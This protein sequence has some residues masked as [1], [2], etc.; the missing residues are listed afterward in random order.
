MLAEPFDLVAYDSARAKVLPWVTEMQNSSP[1]APP[2]H[3]HSSRPTS[4]APTHTHTHT[5]SQSQRGTNG[6]HGSR[7]DDLVSAA[8]YAREHEVGERGVGGEGTKGTDEWVEE[9][10]TRSKSESEGSR[11]GRREHGHGHKHRH[12]HRREKESKK[13]GKTSKNKSKSKTRSTKRSKEPTEESKPTNGGDVDMG[14]R[15]MTE[16]P[17]QS[18]FVAQTDAGPRID[19]MQQMGTQGGQYGGPPPNGFQPQAP[20]GGYVGIPQGYNGFLPQPAFGMGANA[21]NQPGAMPWGQANPNQMRSGEFPTFNP[22]LGNP[23]GL[24]QAFHQGEF[25]QG[26]QPFPYGMPFQSMPPQQPVINPV[27]M[28]SMN[29]NPDSSANMQPPIGPGDTTASAQKEQQQQSAMDRIAEMQQQMLRA[30]EE[31]RLALARQRE[32]EEQEEREKARKEALSVLGGTGRTGHLDTSPG[33]TKSKSGKQAAPHDPSRFP[34]NPAY[35]HTNV[36]NIKTYETVRKLASRSSDT[37]AET[38]EGRGDGEGSESER[39]PRGPKRATKETFVTETTAPSFGH[40]GRPFSHEMTARDFLGH[41]D[42]VEEEELIS[43]VGGGPPIFVMR[44][45]AHEEGPGMGLGLGLSALFG[46]PAPHRDQRSAYVETVLDEEVS[47]N[48]LL[49]QSES[50]RH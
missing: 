44:R 39:S 47:L 35:V 2:H 48:K 18:Q 15:M 19:P 17:G 21:P 4:H 37:P 50:Q 34:T 49:C 27:Q 29:F 1:P 24:A 26:G 5:E 22:A 6:E 40:F 14:T 13:S 25:H 12:R 30:A 42:I 28:P 36:G 3:P 45:V 41:H 32:E 43:P 31:S 20:V 38:V 33:S 16:T 11:G 8:V 7:K 9:G 23:A 10:E 46:K